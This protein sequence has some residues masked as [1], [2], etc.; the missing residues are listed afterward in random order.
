MPRAIPRGET[1]LSF[2]SPPVLSHLQTTENSDTQ[3]SVDVNST[4]MKR[5]Q[6]PY[7]LTLHLYDKA[8][9]NTRHLPRN[10]QICTRLSRKTKYPDF[11]L[12]FCSLTKGIVLTH[13]VKISIFKLSL[14]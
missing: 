2:L 6:L 14:K 9:G 13:T 5:I 11:G 4:L 3:I 12:S 7:Q 1:V 10:S 8:V